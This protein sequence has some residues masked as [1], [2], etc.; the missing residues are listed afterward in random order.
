M[1]IIKTLSLKSTLPIKHLP[2]LP[3]GLR[4]FLECTCTQDGN[5]KVDNDDDDDNNDTI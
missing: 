4:M 3:I 5:D 1:D 2:Q